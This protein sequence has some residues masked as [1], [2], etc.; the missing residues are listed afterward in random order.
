MTRR[1]FVT[2][3]SSWLAVP[4]VLLPALAGR[5]MGLVIH[6]FGH[7]WRTKTA[8]IQHP[9]FCDVL[10]VMDYARGYGIGSLQIG[11]GDWTLDVAHQARASCESYDMRLEGITSL[12]RGEGDLERFSRDLKT[13]LEAGIRLFRV[14]A[15]GRRYETFASREAFLAWKDAVRLSLKLARPGVERLGVRLAVE[16]HKDFEA[17]ELLE[18]LAEAASPSFGVC[19]DL[20]NSLALLEEPMEVVRQL[21]VRTLTVHLKDIAVRPVADG[22][23]MSEVPLGLGILDLPAMIQM[24][25]EKAPEAGLHLEMITRDPLH[26]PCLREEYWAT[27]PQKPGLDLV[28][29]LKKV[30]ERASQDLPKIR[31][32][33]PEAILALEE[34]NVL[35][36]LSAGAASLGFSQM[37]LKALNHDEK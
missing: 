11:V 14:A 5:R 1:R 27:F 13:G 36:S 9:A 28:R 30:R 24:L 19:L 37:N 34:K 6:S 35:E 8:S 29:T 7:R 26:I 22:F 2:F 31:G 4:Q 15:G 10:D 20:G 32:L 3:A 23:E 18:L 21:A 16:N 25:A 12:P 33:P 17:A